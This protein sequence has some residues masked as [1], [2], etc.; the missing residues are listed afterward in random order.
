MIMHVDGESSF[1]KSN[2]LSRY[3]TRD[4]R[5]L[6]VKEKRVITFGGNHKG[7]NV[8]TLFKHGDIHLLYRRL[9]SEVLY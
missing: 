4:A 3:V 5:M 7:K 9:S 8:T 6:H 2:P 1:E